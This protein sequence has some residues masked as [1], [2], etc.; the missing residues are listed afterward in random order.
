MKSFLPLFKTA[1]PASNLRNLLKT[2]GQTAIFWLVFL[3]LLPQGILIL[4]AL[5]GLPKFSPMPFLGWSV[6]IAFSMLGLYSGYTMSWL[7]KGTPLPLDCPNKLVIQGPYRWVRNPMAVAG[8]GQGICVGLILGSYLVV[9]YALAGGVLWHYFV[10]PV[11]EEDLAKRFG[12]AY[13]TYQQKT[14]CWLPKI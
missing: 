13:R 4:S 6:F 10:R 5:L 9:L 11:E 3:Y 14:K 2:L 1:A 12:A 7:G 8:I